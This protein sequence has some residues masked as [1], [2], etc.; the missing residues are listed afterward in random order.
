MTK[1]GD[2]FCKNP[3]TAICS[4]LS[5]KPQTYSFSISYNLVEFDL[6]LHK[7]RHDRKTLIYDCQLSNAPLKLHLI[8]R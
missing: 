8:S 2:V 6:V 3:N 5:Q 1:C 7:P 4:R